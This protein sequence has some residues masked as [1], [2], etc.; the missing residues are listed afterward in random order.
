MGKAKSKWRAE[1]SAA[2]N[3]RRVLPALAAGYFAEVRKVLAADPPPAGLHCLR[4][5]SKRFRYTLELF[6]PC[7]AAGLEQ[8][9]DELR[10]LQDILGACND[11]VTSLE[12]LDRLLRRRPERLA[13]RAHLEKL[14]ADHAAAFRTHWTGEF[15][16]PGQE[17]AW[18]TYLARHSRAP[19]RAR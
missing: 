12:P 2:E 9:L 6:R 7:Y 3:A 10:R 11:A 4:L 8:R 15:D 19:L 14:A 13:V 18:C 16:A 17:D 1:D 5:A